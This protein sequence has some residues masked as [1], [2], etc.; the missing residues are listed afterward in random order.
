MTANS[1]LPVEDLTA[2]AARAE[3]KLLAAEIAEA[4]RA[5]FQDDAPVLEDAVYDEK[6]RRLNALEGAFPELKGTEAL[7]DKVG[8]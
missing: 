8:A 1:A 3:H 4:D 2:E 6:R 5:Y 7:S